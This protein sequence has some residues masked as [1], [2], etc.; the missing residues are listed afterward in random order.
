MC[1]L[2]YI[3]VCVCNKR[4]EKIPTK[5]LKLVTLHTQK[6]LGFFTILSHLME[7]NPPALFV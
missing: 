4:E 6:E 2:T 3:C 7:D 1:V 5:L